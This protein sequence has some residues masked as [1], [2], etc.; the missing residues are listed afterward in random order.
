MVRRG[1]TLFL[2]IALVA[3]T[4]V[5]ARAALGSPTVVRRDA[6]GVPHITAPSQH[7]LAFTMGLTLAEDRPFQ[8]DLYRRAG[9]GRLSEVLGA[10]SDDEYLRSDILMRQ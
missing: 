8:L 1:T 10:G 5:S 6:F 2:L 9:S 3:T 7:A 4:I